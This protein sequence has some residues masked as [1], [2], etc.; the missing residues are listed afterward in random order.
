MLFREEIKK[1]L[2]IGLN[3]Q[4]PFDG[5]NFVPAFASVDSSEGAWK[6]FSRVSRSPD[7]ILLLSERYIF[8]DLIQ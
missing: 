2:M 4:V 1:Q 8:S 5:H 7:C 3:E 6:R